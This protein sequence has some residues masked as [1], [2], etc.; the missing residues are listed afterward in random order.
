MIIQSHWMTGIERFMFSLLNNK[1]CSLVR[2]RPVTY[3]QFSI[4]QSQTAGV[5][6]FDWKFTLI[7]QQFEVTRSYFFDVRGQFEI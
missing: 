4:S 1:W 3:S 5:D 2:L 6:Y 7:Y